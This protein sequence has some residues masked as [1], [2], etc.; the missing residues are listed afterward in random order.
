M[1]AMLWAQRIINDKRKYS[2]VP[3]MLKEQVKEILVESGVWELIG[4]EDK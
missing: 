1:I 3:R 2:E 4:E